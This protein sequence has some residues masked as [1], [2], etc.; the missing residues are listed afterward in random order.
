MTAQA[1]DGEMIDV[2]VRLPRHAVERSL[3][4]IRAPVEFVPG[5]ELALIK[6]VL[7][8]HRRRAGLIPG[9]RSAEPVWNMVLELYAAA[10]ESQR[11]SVIKLCQVSGSSVT[12]ALR[13][14]ELL[15][16]DGFVAREPDDRDG[17]SQRIVMLP[18]L[19]A[20]VESWLRDLLDDLRHL[21]ASAGL[22]AR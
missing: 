10:A 18:R 11:F 1:L 14:I 17:R 16:A 15:E 19:K 12:T 7:A 5:G 20:A 6:A 2:T 9:M 21:E 13:H 4:D 8:S 3:R 22:F